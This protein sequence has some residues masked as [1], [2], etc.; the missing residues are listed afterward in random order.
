MAD[1]K[2]TDAANSAAVKT[3]YTKRILKSFEP[4]TMFYKLA[5]VREPIPQGGGKTIE[6]TR[7]LKVPYL[8]A[9]NSSEFTA[10]QVYLSASTVSATLHNRDGYVQLSRFTVMTSISNILDRAAEKVKKSAAATVDVLVRND[11]GMAV[12]CYAETS[13]INM[14]NLKIDGG[15][16]DSRGNGTLGTTAGTGTGARVWSHDKAA[17]GDRF[18]MYHNKARVAQSSL[19][20]TAIAKSAMSVKTLQHASSVLTGNDIET[21]NGTYHAIMHPNVAYQVT[22]SA[23]F[24]GWNAYT[25]SKP[26][27]DD[28]TTLGKIGNIMIHTTTLAYRFP[29]SGDT[30]A[31]ASG[32]LYCTLVFGDEAY[33]VSEIGSS[34]GEGFNF[35]LKASGD[36]ST[37][38]PTNMIKQAAY[39]VT[40]VG[41]ILNKSA[42]LWILTTEKV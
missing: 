16:L 23:G 20:K 17:A 2:S 3:Y 34:A 29:L 22:T 26:M 15:A 11:I 40:M 33:G 42:G 41:K 37:N 30:M 13:S 25:S 9:D 32:A 4:S 12:L 24:K 36:Q 38:D 27:S 6:F 5:P 21:I 28:P 14:N 7:Y 10:Q 18:P 39:S 35:Y 1:Q 8:Y 19:V 31:T